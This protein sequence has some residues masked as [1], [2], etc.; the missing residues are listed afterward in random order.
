MFEAENRAVA[1]EHSIEQ[2]LFTGRV[3]GERLRKLDERRRTLGKCAM[4]EQQRAI[5][6]ASAPWSLQP[7]TAVVAIVFG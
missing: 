5:D 7:F 3:T 2:V 6:L 1:S 4:H